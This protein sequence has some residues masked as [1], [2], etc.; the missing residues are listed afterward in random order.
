MSAA[1]GMVVIDTS[2]NNK[3]FVK[4]LKNMTAQTNGLTASVKKLGSVIASVFA[5]REII[6]FGKECIELGSN[7]AEVQ[8]VVDA[9]FGNMTDKV[10]TFAD[11]AIQNFGMSKLAAKKTASTYMAMAKGM[12]V[13]DEAAADMSITLA[14]LTGGVAS[15]YNIS[16]DLAD[17]KLK[18]VFTGETE[19]L[20][21]LGVVM[22]QDNLKA[23]ALSKGI[24]KSYDAMSQA[25]KVALRYNFVLDSLAMASGDFARTSDSWANQTRILSMQWQEFMSIMGQSLIT[26]LTPVVKML[27]SIVSSL[28]SMANTFNSFV[29]AFFGGANQQ[30]QQTQSNAAA[31]SGEIG[32]NVENQEALTAATKETAKAQQGMLANFDEINALSEDTESSTTMGGTAS[33]ITQPVEAEISTT[34]ESEKLLGFFSKLKIAFQP[35]LEM[36]DHLK[37][38][39]ATGIS[40]FL[41]EVTDLMGDLADV[42]LGDTTISEFLAD[43]TPVQ[44]VLVGIAAAIGAIA[45]ASA[46]LAGLAAIKGFIQGVQSLNAVGIISKLAE[47]FLLTASGAG[48]LSEAMKVVFG[49]GSIL[50]GVGTIVGGAVLAVTNFLSMLKNGFSW[51]QEALMVLGVALT[52]VGAIILGAPALVAGVVAAVIAAVATAAILIKEHWTEIKAFG[53]SAWEGI[54]T[55]WSNVTAWFANNVMQ[56]FK[57]SFKDFINGLIGYVEGFINFFVRGINKIIDAVNSLSFD[58]PDVLGGGTIGFDLPNV[59]KISLPRLATGAVIPPNREFLAVLGDQKSGNNIEAPEGLIRQIVREEAGGGSTTNYLLR[60]ILDAIKE[61]GD[62]YLDGRKIAQNTVR[63]INAMSRCSSTSILRL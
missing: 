40:W 57:E 62:I 15:F 31:V 54:K 16:Q 59:S 38:T 5:V 63:H 49:K 2:L 26:V 24:A 10:E 4:G 44:T 22:T 61:G 48:T 25:E 58:I 13:A 18:S 8:N 51:A 53:I 27:N 6:N 43:L 9:A 23:Y 60:D 14:G 19:T 33:L 47:V 3:G 37:N 50:A 11:S 42:I 56:P 30:I 32:A 39:L 36:L 46:G 20:K 12:G 52:A 7:V 41:R 45:V 17:V 29:S 34:P 55:A 35:V 21:D 28:I 1:D